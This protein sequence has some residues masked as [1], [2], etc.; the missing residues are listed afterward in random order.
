M[1][2]VLIVEDDDGIRELLAELLRGEGYQVLIA[3]NGYEALDILQHET[4]S[5]VVLL[6]RHM[7]YDGHK[8]IAWLEETQ[9]VGQH[10]VVIMPA[11]IPRPQEQEW[12][13]DGTIAALL[14]KPFDLD[15]MLA[16]V[17]QLAD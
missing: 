2:R 12:L 9:R 1:R 13:A 17:Q 11:S 5:L 16:L 15:E 14:P 4:A 7:P 6:D 10:R 8:V 3:R